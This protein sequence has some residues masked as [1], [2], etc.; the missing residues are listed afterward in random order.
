[1]GCEHAHYRCRFLR[2]KSPPIVTRTAGPSRP[3]YPRTGG[4]DLVAGGLTTPRRGLKRISLVTRGAPSARLRAR[5]AAAGSIGW[6][7]SA[8]RRWFND[9]QGWG[10][11][12]GGGTAARPGLCA[13]HAY[14][15]ALKPTPPLFRRN[16]W[17]AP[18][19]TQGMYRWFRQTHRGM[20][21]L[22]AAARPP[23]FHRPG[24]SLTWRSVLG[25]GK[26]Q[27]GPPGASGWNYGQF[28]H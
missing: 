26:P 3:R 4:A 22:R 19:C 12:P 13:L 25:G 18:L 8:R 28:R 7:C 15:T 23:R 20:G 21:I 1:M 14:C 10:T 17:L 27:A 2:F 9:M 6:A 16:G 24:C 5:T 11:L